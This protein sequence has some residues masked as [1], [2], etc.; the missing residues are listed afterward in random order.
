[1]FCPV[2]RA[3]YGPEVTECPDCHVALVPE[4][5]EEDAPTAYAVL[6]RGEN[7]NFGSK[8]AE[9]LQ[10]FGINSV[11]VP[12]D[13]LARNSRNFFDVAEWPLFGAAVAVTVR[14]IPAAERI[15]E[16]LLQQEPGEDQG[17]LPEPTDKAE[18]AAK[19][20]ELPLDWDPATATVELWRGDDVGTLNFAEDALE[21]VGIPARHESQD[22]YVY[23]LY[24][25]PEDADRG[26]EIVKEVIEGKPPV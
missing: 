22:G 24:V 20:P 6:W 10:N 19:V 8:L 17:G 15:K 2:C 18:N 3:E 26:R 13:V 4:L 16:K 7:E 12:L 9:E 23:V 5:P 14:D 11:T 21:G 25:R 1:M